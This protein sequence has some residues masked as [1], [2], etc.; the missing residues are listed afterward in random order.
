MYRICHRCRRK[1]TVDRDRVAAKRI[2]TRISRSRDNYESRLS[3]VE[4]KL[5]EMRSKEKK[6]KKKRRYRCIPIPENPIVF[7]SLISALKK[8]FHYRIDTLSN[9]VRSPF[10]FFRIITKSTFRSRSTEAIQLF[11]VLC[12]VCDFIDSVSVEKKFRILQSV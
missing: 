11:I 2:H 4:R 12:S 9:K 6:K 7:H 8:F 10:T 1:F 3:D 5:S